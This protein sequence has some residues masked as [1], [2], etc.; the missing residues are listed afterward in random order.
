V[1]ELKKP[2]M[3]MNEK[4]AEQLIS[5]MRL[6]KIN[7]GILIG[8]TLQVY[9]ELPNDNKS[10]AKI[11]DI[12]FIR[13]LNEGIAF[14]KFLSKKEY[15]FEKFQKYCEDILADKEKKEKSQKYINLLCSTEGVEIIRDLLKEKLSTEYPKEI[16]DEIISEINIQISRKVKTVT[17]IIVHLTDPHKIEEPP[18]NELMPNQAKKLC[19]ENGFDL[20]GAV[21]FA[22]KN[23]TANGYWANPN[24]QFLIDDW[25]LL[26]NDYKHHILHIFYIHAN[27]IT[28]D[29]IKTRKDNSDKI[30]LQIKYEN[31]L[32]EDSRSGIQF[33][34]WFKKTISY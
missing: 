14:I 30:D 8:E 31:E 28:E 4:N 23:K 12:S 26:L 10:P 34:K 20:N 2:N 19:K 17:P 24:I 16:I 32:F 29:Q 18:H 22:S 15:T 21:T 3:P 1:V 6:L 27:S 25:W 5:Y 7:F 9:Y 13:D 33:V 11:I